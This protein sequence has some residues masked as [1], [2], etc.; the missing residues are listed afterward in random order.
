MTGRLSNPIT[1]SVFLNYERI[2]L[3]ILIGAY[4]VVYSK[5]QYELDWEEDQ[6]TEW[7]IVEMKK[8]NLT[9]KHRLHIYSQS[10]IRKDELPIN[11]N[12]PKISPKIDI[13]F[14]NWERNQNPCEYFIEAKNLSLESWQKKTGAAV[15]STH[16]MNRYIETGICNFTTARYVNGSLVGYVLNGDIEPIVQKLNERLAEPQRLKC[17]FENY[18]IEDYP[19]I[20]SSEHPVENFSI[21]IK[22]VFLSFV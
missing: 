9:S 1:N 16:Y 7:L 20:Y 6:F 19:Y 15:S 12:H 14:W 18:N 4:Q 21:K 11:D 2:C 13:G 10:L 3:R 17:I 22:H 5:K 8:H